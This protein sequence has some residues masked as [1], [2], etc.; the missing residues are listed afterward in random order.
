M[1][2]AKKLP[3]D[4]DE[5]RAAM[6]S[7]FDISK[8]ISVLEMFVLYAAR[9]DPPTEEEMKDAFWNEETWGNVMCKERFVTTIEEEATRALRAILCHLPSVLR[10]VECFYLQAMHFLKLATERRINSPRESASGKDQRD[11]KWLT[12]VVKAAAD[13]LAKNY[14]K[15][16]QEDQAWRD[17]CAGGKK[18]EQRTNFLALCMVGEPASKQTTPFAKFWNDYRNDKSLRSVSMIREF[19]EENLSRHDAIKIAQRAAWNQGCTIDNNLGCRLLTSAEFEEGWPYFKKHLILRIKEYNELRMLSLQ[20]YE[21]SKRWAGEFKEHLALE[22]ATFDSWKR[23]LMGS[24]GWFCFRDKTVEWPKTAWR[25]IEWGKISTACKKAAKVLLCE[26]KKRSEWQGSL[27]RQHELKPGEGEKLIL[28]LP[29]W[30]RRIK[31]EG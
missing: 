26:G 20:N 29:D 30:A 27:Y 17:M 3:Y 19:V 9:F 22:G 15:I 13:V 16:G 1:A 7:L 28:P 25:K 10:D 21:N 18:P 5:V 24:N 6:D 12:F 31:G 14:A 23:T 4:L 11:E 2:A 8:H